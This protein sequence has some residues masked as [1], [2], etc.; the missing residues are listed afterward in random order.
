MGHLTRYRVRC[1]DSRAGA[2][3]SIYFAITPDEPNNSAPLGSTVIGES[4][5]Y[6]TGRSVV[7]SVFRSQRC[8]SMEELRCRFIFEHSVVS[9]LHSGLV[10]LT[11]GSKV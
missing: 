2:K 6:C 10:V 3:T 8:V 7:A 5:V 4:I 11:I 9:H 1:V